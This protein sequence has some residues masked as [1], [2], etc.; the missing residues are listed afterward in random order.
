MLTKIN[1]SLNVEK[2]WSASS[3][4]GVGKAYL[5]LPAAY[6]NKRVFAA[7]SKGVI[8]ALNAETGK[9]LWR[10]KTT[11]PIIAGPTAYAK[12]VIV[13]TS[14]AKVAAFNQKDGTQAWITTTPSEV[15]AKP[16]ASGNTLIVKTID[17]QITALDVNTGTP[18]WH[19]QEDLP[20]LIL[21][22]SSSIAFSDNT[23]VSGFANGKVSALNIES[24]NLLWQTAIAI[25]EGGNIIENMIDIDATPVIQNDTVFAASYQ[26]NVASLDLKNGQARW[27]HPVSTFAGITASNEQVFV[28]EANSAIIA[29]NSTTGNADWTQDALLYR[30]ITGPVL[31]NNTLVVGDN[32]GYLHFLASKDGALLARVKAT[33]KSLLA[34]PLVANNTLYVTTNNGYVIA[35][36]ITS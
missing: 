29:F 21:R 26:G 35:Y 24:G 8:T 1:N 27:Q 10:I 25:P 7:S 4:D 11:L 5:K 13:G 19:Y 3:G 2:I 33:N 6:D 31:F 9:Q 18:L 12:L 15:L 22:G 36:R 16:A 23:L 20:S 30:K 28:S 14:N 32:E 17:G 34:T